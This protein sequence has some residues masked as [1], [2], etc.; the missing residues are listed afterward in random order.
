MS[1]RRTFLKNTTLATTSLWVPNMLKAF[2]QTSLP[3]QDQIL[4]VIQLSGGNDGLNTLVSYEDDAYY[5]KRPTIAIPKQKV[6]KLTDTQG[7][8]PA[9]KPLRYI[10]DQ[11][12]MSILNGV[13]YA[14][15]IRSHFRAMDIWHTASDSSEV[16]QTGW[17]GR[18]L[19]RHCEGC[20]Q[21][22]HILNMDQQLQLAVRGKLR[23]GFAVGDLRRLKEVVS[24]QRLR[25]IE[26][27]RSVRDDNV[28]YLYR[29]LA[30]TLSTTDY[31]YE[32]AQRFRSKRKYPGG[33][34]GKNL[35]QVAELIISGL[36]TQ[37]YYTSHGNF[38]THYSQPGKHERL[39][40]MYA[41]AV[42]TFVADLRDHKRL[43]DVLIVTFSEFGRRVAENGSSGTDHGTSN[44]VWLIGQQLK[45]Q[46]IV[47]PPPNLNRLIEGDLTHQIDFRQVYATIL[48]NWLHAPSEKIL[49]K[50]FPKLNI[51]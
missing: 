33:A 43:Q 16:W 49:G 34:L 9:L 15:P 40:G 24:V 17:L 30:N 46:G 6:L 44:C 45:K 8:N 50:S 37:V 4:V 47:N 18:Y 13:G 51:L 29:T 42:S 38:D 48:E 41:E 12:W 19:D 7:L 20:D 28:S 21:P 39:L 27:P 3:A 5:Q 32:H 14:N 11:G 22:H 10:Y 35:K 1:T 23:N 26:T 2:E 25:D 31:L 36:D